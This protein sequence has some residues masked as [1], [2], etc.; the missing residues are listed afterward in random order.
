MRYLRSVQSV[1][2][3]RVF[4]LWHSDARLSAVPS[5]CLDGTSLRRTLLGRLYLVTAGLL[6]SVRL[7]WQLHGHACGQLPKAM[8]PQDVWCVRRKWLHDRMYRERMRIRMHR[9]HQLPDRLS[10][11]RHRHGTAWP[12]CRS[13]SADTGAASLSWPASLADACTA[14]GSIPDV[15]YRCCGTLRVE[16]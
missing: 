7:L 5:G 15:S 8:R 12:C 3:R 2:L 9:V 10:D 6:R 1:L 4:S 13:P 11:L 16:I 14:A